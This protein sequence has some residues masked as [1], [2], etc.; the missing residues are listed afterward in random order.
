MTNQVR[1]AELGLHWPWL[2]SR[3]WSY[4]ARPLL[5]CNMAMWR[6]DILAIN[7]FDSAATRYGLIEDTDIEWRLLANGVKGAS[8]LGRGCVFHLDHPTRKND[9]TTNK[10]YMKVKQARGEVWAVEG[11]DRILKRKEG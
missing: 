10:E 11:I 1:Y 9:D 2:I 8:L 4:K 5:G 3:L 7:G 6:D